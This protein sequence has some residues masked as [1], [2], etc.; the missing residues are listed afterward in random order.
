MSVKT[1]AVRTRKRLQERI[2]ELRR[3]LINSD[4]RA[5]MLR[6][7]IHH[8]LTSDFNGVVGVCRDCG[9][10]VVEFNS[11]PEFV[12]FRPLAEKSDYFALCV[13]PACRRHGGEGFCSGFDEMPLWIRPFD[14][15][16]LSREEVFLLPADNGYRY[17]YREFVDHLYDEVERATGIPLKHFKPQ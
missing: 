10:T 17:D 3:A 6:Q 4:L 7:L 15:K 12:K 1:K 16:K 2:T 14:L 8:M 9:S 11:N 13:N 5:E